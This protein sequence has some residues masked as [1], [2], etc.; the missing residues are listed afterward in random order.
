MSVVK[1]TSLVFHTLK[2]DNVSEKLVVDA[3]M[4]L[5]AKLNSDGELRCSVLL[6]D[7]ATGDDYAAIKL[8]SEDLLSIRKLCDEM[9]AA[10]ALYKG[11][12][13]EAASV[14]GLA[15]QARTQEARRLRLNKL[16]RP[17]KELD[18]AAKATGRGALELDDEDFDDN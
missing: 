15:E 14:T 6:N 5:R 17:V 2:R 4:H 16:L 7:A 9:L 1:E 8:N 10:E 13:L 3:E 11:K 18:E 12:M